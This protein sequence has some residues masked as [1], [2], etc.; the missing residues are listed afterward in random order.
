MSVWMIFAVSFTAILLC[1]GLAFTF[2]GFHRA[3][4]GDEEAEL[5][6]RAPNKRIG[7]TRGRAA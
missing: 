6:E 3:N 5:R 2:L 7:N 4:T 1:S